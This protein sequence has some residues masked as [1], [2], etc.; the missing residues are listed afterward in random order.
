[1][2]WA[3]SFALDLIA[4]A[5]ALLVFAYVGTEGPCMATLQPAPAWP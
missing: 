4:L 5:V 3:L 1:M 2:G